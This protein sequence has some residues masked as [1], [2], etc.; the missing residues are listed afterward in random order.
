MDHSACRQKVCLICYEKATHVAS[1]AIIHSVQ[2]YLIEDYNPDF[3]N[4]ACG[5]CTSCQV[6]LYKFSKGDFS[7]F[8][9]QPIGIT[10]MSGV[11][12]LPRS[13]DCYCYI[14]SKA[15]ENG[16]QCVG[17]GARPQKKTMVRICPEC[18]SL[19]GKGLEHICTA[20]RRRDNLLDIL[21]SP[22]KEAI[23]ALVV[24]KKLQAGGDMIFT[25]FGRPYQLELNELPKLSHDA[26]TSM[27]LQANLTQNQLI[28]VSSHIRKDLGRTAIEPKLKDFLVLRNRKCE[29]F[30]DVHLLNSQ[31]GVFCL[32]VQ[33]FIN[34]IIQERCQSSNIITKIGMDGGKGSLKVTMSLLSQSNSCGYFKET[35]TRKIFLLAVVP[36]IPESYEVCSDVFASLPKMPQQFKFSADLKVINL[37]LG[38]GSHASMYPCPFCYFKKGSTGSFKNRTLE[39]ICTL[40]EQWQTIGKGA[41]SDLKS[42]MNCVHKPISIF[43][44]TGN[45]IDIVAIPEL[46]ILLGITNKLFKEAMKEWPEI[47]E[48]P[49]SLHLV[50]G[51][52]HNQDFEGNEARKLLKNCEKLKSLIPDMRRTRSSVMHPGWKYY[53]AFRT[54][55]DVVA[56]C[57]GKV[58]SADIEER[59]NMF[60]DAYNN[61][62]CSITSK[63]HIL[64]N[65]VL[66]MVSLSNQGL[67]D[68]S[69]QSLEAT[70]HTFEK[71]WLKYLVKDPS[72]PEYGSRLKRALVEFNSCH[73]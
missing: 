3:A 42:Y 65:H 31:L 40:N 63:V 61:S 48:W 67:A 13:K 69:E 9:R 19:C 41:A 11:R 24:Q 34:Y 36:N 35:G 58:V 53:E 70:H 62:G 73:L 59:I 17:H 45:V 60:Q 46:H 6:A 71:I 8:I 7:T 44:S 57:F 55:N 33:E 14:C 10:I 64:C 32:D 23:A 51:E 66:P 49:K 5:V 47:L 26:M 37:V 29:E 28:A 54:F 30:F 56:G 18:F 4:W 20:K 52:Y 68:M 39:D 12:V 22:E 15:K 25:T 2:T 1:P 43:P 21:S 38:L 72:H 16:L 50:Q 27:Q